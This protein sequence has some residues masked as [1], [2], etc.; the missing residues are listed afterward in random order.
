VI[1]PARQPPARSRYLAATGIPRRGVPDAVVWP[2][3]GVL[4]GLGTEPDL[5]ARFSG[6]YQGR[7]RIA[8]VV[9]RELRRHSERPTADLPSG[10]HDRVIAATR[11]YQ[12]LLLGSGRLERTEATEAD[13]VEIAEVALQLRAQSESAGGR[14]GG[15]A[16]IIV[17]ARRQAHGQQQ[18]HILLTNDGGASIIAGRHGMP[19]RHF[20]DVLAEFACAQQDLDAGQCLRAFNGALPVSAPPAHCRPADAEYFTCVMTEDGCGL[21]DAD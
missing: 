16:E 11:A 21:C 17:L 5:L 8:S 10:D 20:G 4:L 18:K 15:E 3:T 7:I 6:H 1:A 9:A 13:L 19:S 14:H 2:D 12:C